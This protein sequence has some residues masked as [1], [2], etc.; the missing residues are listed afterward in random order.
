MIVS[1]WALAADFMIDNLVCFSPES[2]PESSAFYAGRHRARDIKHHNKVFRPSYGGCIPRSISWIVSIAPALGF[3]G[4][5]ILCKQTRFLAT[6]VLP[7]R[8]GSKLS[9][10]SVSFGI[11]IESS[12][13]SHCCAHFSF[14]FS[15]VGVLG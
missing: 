4:C 8:C 7:R 11:P 1:S 12:A 9:V 14:D 10:H 3:Y 5:R 6:K 15:F 13:S 2:F